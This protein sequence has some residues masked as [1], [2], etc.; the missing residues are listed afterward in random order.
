MQVGVLCS[1]DE[2]GKIIVSLV[3]RAAF[4]MQK[5]A[6]QREERLAM[7]E[8]NGRIAQE[9]LAELR[10]RTSDARSATDLAGD[11][12]GDASCTDGGQGQLRQDVVGQDAS[13][14]TRMDEVHGTRDS[15][16]LTGSLASTGEGLSARCAILAVGLVVTS[17]VD[18]R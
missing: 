15:E 2:S 13:V 9:D 18:S 16:S 7:A 11:L 1:P 12:A 4:N 17:C 3:P 10:A 5:M 6:A 8:Y 14:G